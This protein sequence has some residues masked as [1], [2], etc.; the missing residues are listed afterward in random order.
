LRCRAGLARGAMET[1]GFSRRFRQF[2]P[3]DARDA[4]AGR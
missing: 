4:A 1:V 2:P 3:R